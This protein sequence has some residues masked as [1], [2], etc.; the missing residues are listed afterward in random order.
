MANCSMAKKILLFLLALIVVIQFIRPA[1]NISTTVTTQD[2]MQVYPIPDGVK[3]VLQKA[4]YDC[5]SNDTRYPWYTNIQ[6]IGW[7]MANHVTEGKK[8]LNF[9]E[10]GNYPLRRQSKKL[11]KSAKEVQEGEMPLTSYIWQ[12]KD[13][14]LTEAEKQAYITWAN[15]LSAK[16]AEQLPPEEKK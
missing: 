3:I 13:A 1:K 2:I 9:S 14:A 10:F 4:C 8:E 15:A 16:M 5:H 7:W 6:P 12:H 11:K